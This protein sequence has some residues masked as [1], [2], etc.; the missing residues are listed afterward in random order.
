M[1]QLRF[2][3]WVNFRN[4]SILQMHVQFPYNAEARINDLTLLT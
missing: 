1:I 3:S 4:E 2:E